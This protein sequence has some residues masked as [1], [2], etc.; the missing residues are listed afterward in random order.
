[1][2]ASKH[3][4]VNYVDMLFSAF[5]NS[6][7]FRNAICHLGDF[8]TRLQVLDSRGAFLQRSPLQNSH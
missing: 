6:L 1:M 5:T 8:H 3:N 4:A 7:F 2:V